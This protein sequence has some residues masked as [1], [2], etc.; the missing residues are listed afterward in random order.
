MGLV[1]RRGAAVPEHVVDRG[2]G[3]AGR[4]GLHEQLDG[5]QRAGPDLDL[6]RGVVLDQRAGV[7]ARDEV[8]VELEHAV[9]AQHVRDEV[10]GEQ[11]Q[12]V[13]VVGGGE[14]GQRE[15]RG[16]DLGALEERDGLSW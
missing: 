5:M 16:G 6:L 15:V 12:P 11:G 8:V 10:V 3:G 7:D 14:P 2:R 9:D 1:A 4:V 13:Q